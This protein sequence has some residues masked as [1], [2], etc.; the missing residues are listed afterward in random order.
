MLTSSV[1]PCQVCQ[2]KQTARYDFTRVIT[3]MLNT[4]L[5]RC[6]SGGGGTASAEEE[7]QTKGESVDK[8]E[9]RKIKAEQNIG[10]DDT[11]APE[12]NS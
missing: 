12:S 11:P 8:G 6:S 1:T 9:R 7:V 2:N 4:S 10:G 5:F 3:K